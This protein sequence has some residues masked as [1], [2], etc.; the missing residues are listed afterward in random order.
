MYIARDTEH[1]LQPTRLLIP[2]ACKQIVPYLYVQLSCWTSTLGFETCRKH[3][4]NS[5]ISLTKVHF[6]GLYYT[7]IFLSLQT[8]N[9]MKIK[10]VFISFCSFYSNNF[11]VSSKKLNCMLLFT[12]FVE[13]TCKSWRKIHAFSGLCTCTLHKQFFINY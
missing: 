8:P 13:L 4:K 9:L 11:R 10:T 3:R 7:V 6:V 2:L 1:T 12:L 5:N